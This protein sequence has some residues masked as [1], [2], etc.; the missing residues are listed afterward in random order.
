M[1]EYKEVSVRNILG[2]N[3]SPIAKTNFSRIA[4]CWMLWCG[5][6]ICLSELKM[7]GSVGLRSMQ[8]IIIKIQGSVKNDCDASESD[9]IKD[10]GTVTV[11]APSSSCYHYIIFLPIISSSSIM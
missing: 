10:L 7:N 8:Y 3:A 11:F 9:D 1:R 5:D 6:T 2:A 4:L